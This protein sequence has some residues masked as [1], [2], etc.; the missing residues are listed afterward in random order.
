MDLASETEW[1][2]NA[3]AD[4]YW[5]CHPGKVVSSKTVKEAFSSFNEEMALGKKKRKTIWSNFFVSI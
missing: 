1:D 3:C 4:F 5:L 2:L